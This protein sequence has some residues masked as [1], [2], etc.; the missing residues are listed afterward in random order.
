MGD[1]A[2]MV[3]GRSGEG[4]RPA[5]ESGLLAGRAIACHG[6]FAEAAWTYERGV[7][8][9]PGGRHGRKPRGLSDWL[10]ASLAEWRSLPRLLKH[11]GEMTGHLL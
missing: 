3:Y 8:R 5:V 7:I 2:G 1:A 4:I 9:R 6:D 11:P 10:P